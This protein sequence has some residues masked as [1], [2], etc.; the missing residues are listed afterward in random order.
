[1][2]KLGKIYANGLLNQKQDR[3]TARKWSQ[4]AIDT[5]RKTGESDPEVDRRL[6]FF[7]INPNDY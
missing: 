4:K 3:E 5:R 1:M 7:G 6:R 2:D